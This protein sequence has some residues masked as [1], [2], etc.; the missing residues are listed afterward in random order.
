MSIHVEYQEQHGNCH[1]YQTR[2]YQVNTYQVAQRHAE[3][4]GQRH[5]LVDGR[6]NSLDLTEPS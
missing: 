6:N 5:R 4:T 1:H 2:Q 3:S